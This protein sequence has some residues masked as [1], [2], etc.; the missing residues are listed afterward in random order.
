MDG[1][2]KAFKA[3]RSYLESRGCETAVRP[4][5]MSFGERRAVVEVRRARDGATLCYEPV[6]CREGDAG[7]EFVRAMCAGGLMPNALGEVGL[8]L[9]PGSPAELELRLAALGG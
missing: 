8:G 7:A 3:L 4:L 2:E 9:R 1:A 6:F 5:E